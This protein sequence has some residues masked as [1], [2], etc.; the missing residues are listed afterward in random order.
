MVSNATTGILDNSVP[1]LHPGKT[2]CRLASCDG[3]DDDETVSHQ[4]VVHHGCKSAK[5][6]PRRPFIVFMAGGMG[7]GK[8]Y[9]LR[10][11]YNKGY[12]DTS[13][14]VMV[15]PDR[16]KCMLPEMREL[17]R[18]DRSTAGT[19]THAESTYIAEIAQ[20]CALQ[21]G[22]NIIVDV[23]HFL[24]PACTLCTTTHS[25]AH[26]VSQCNPRAVQSWKLRKSS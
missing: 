19:L 16:L 7:V 14:Y 6:S 21:E 8:S 2:M 13:R 15:D 12:F 24:C 17:I 25:N 3:D 5:L 11:A 26:A 9:V 20:E 22:K 10:W 18:R 23:S 1:D 4:E